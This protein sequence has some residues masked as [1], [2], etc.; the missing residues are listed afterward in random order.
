MNERSF[1]KASLFLPGIKRR[2]FVTC[3]CLRNAGASAHPNTRTYSF[4]DSGS[5]P[6]PDAGH[7]QPDYATGASSNPDSTQHRPA[8][9]RRSVEGHFLRA[10][11]F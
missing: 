10:T 5:N 3:F 2:S 11:G 9:I 8:A 7:P 6:N 1:K 4:T